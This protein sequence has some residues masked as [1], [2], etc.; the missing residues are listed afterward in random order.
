MYVVYLCVPHVCSVHRGQKRMI[1][2][3]MVITWGLGT[4]LGSSAMETRAL[5]HGVIPLGLTTFFDLT[6]LCFPFYSNIEIINV[7]YWH[8]S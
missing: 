8:N 3:Q 6:P 5:N 7:R 2:P 4:Q 1:E